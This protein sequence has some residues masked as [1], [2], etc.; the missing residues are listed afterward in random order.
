[1]SALDL[2][3]LIWSFAKAVRFEW[4]LAKTAKRFNPRI[5]R[6]DNPVRVPGALA[7]PGGDEK[8]VGGNNF[9]RRDGWR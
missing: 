1:M 5:A 8:C 7:L 4:K 6:R 2:I 9:E 3:S